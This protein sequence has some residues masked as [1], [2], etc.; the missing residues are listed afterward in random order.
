MCRNLELVGQKNL[1]QILERMN[2]ARKCLII[3]LSPSPTGPARHPLRYFGAGGY[4]L[5]NPASKQKAKET[6]NG[7]MGIPE[8]AGKVFCE[9]V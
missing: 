3:N 5:A 6:L 9:L 2:T 8:T 1:P 4:D 7:L